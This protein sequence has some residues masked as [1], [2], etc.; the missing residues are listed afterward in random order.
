MNLIMINNWP[1][2]TSLL[3]VKFHLNTISLDIP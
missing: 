1:F 3:I 2:A